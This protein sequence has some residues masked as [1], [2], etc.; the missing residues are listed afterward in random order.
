V[1]ISFLI[2]ECLSPELAQL[3]H[4]EGYVATSVRDRGWTGLK[5][6]EVVAKALEIDTVLVTRN[7]SDYRGA[8][9]DA[10]GGLLRKVDVHPGLV[11]L[12]TEREEF[13]IPKQLW[14]FGIALDEL[15]GE[16]DLVNQALEVV[17]E[18]DGAVVVTRYELP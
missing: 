12:D 17:E 8:A 2:D 10:A 18:E 15:K 4:R 14:L 16:T 6:F 3:A 7:A 13:D 11:C 9:P 5:D 1:A